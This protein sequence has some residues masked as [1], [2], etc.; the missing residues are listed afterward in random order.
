MELDL[1]RG[2]WNYHWWGNRKLFDIVSGLGEDTAA[3]AL[4]SQFSFPSLKGMLAH[5][6]GADRI[7]LERWTGKKPAKLL[8]DADFTSLAD[9]R[10][11]W[12]GLE[13]EQRRFVDALTPSELQRVVVHTGLDGKGTFRARDHDHHGQGLAAVHRHGRLLPHRLGPAPALRRSDGAGAERP[14]E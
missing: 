13:D 2:S 8:G 11:R 5:I 10:K 3:R 6:H 9:L 1:I 14:W 12:D 4:G 7:W